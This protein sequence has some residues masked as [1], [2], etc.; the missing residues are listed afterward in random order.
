MVAV[1]TV[2]ELKIDEA[3]IVTLE[4]QSDDGPLTAIIPRE[5]AV[6]SLMSLLKGIARASEKPG[7]AYRMLIQPIGF[8]VERVGNPGQS[9]AV[10][11]LNLELAPDTYLRIALTVGWARA[12]SDALSTLAKAMQPGSAH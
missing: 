4:L 1:A 3:G 9:G 6:D 12:L 10:P 8:A 2:K 11:C 5:R 7:P